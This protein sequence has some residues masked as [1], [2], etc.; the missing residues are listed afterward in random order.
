MIKNIFL[1]E[2]RQEA[3]KVQYATECKNYD[4]IEATVKMNVCFPFPHFHAY[5]ERLTAVLNWR[6]GFC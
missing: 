1:R 4:H 2:M 3:D 5:M 6:F